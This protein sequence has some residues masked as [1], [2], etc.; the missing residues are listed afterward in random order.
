MPA[1]VWT[2]SPPPA[3]GLPSVMR[4]V[5]PPPPENPEL[6]EPQFGNA[7]WLNTFVTQKAKH[8]A[9]NN[10][11][12]DG[13]DD[14]LDAETEVEMRLS[15]AGPAGLQKEVEEDKDLAAGDKVIIRRYEVYK[16]LGAYDA[17]SHEALCDD[18]K[19]CPEAVGPY[20][21]SQIAAANL[22]PGNL[23]SAQVTTAGLSIAG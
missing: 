11:V 18:P 21:G 7:V 16:Y 22:V 17:E 3:V 20:I 19:I 13:P 2:V 6:P 15:Q 10:M 8:A 23:V 12:Q 5:A 4:A 9:L 1:P 14:P